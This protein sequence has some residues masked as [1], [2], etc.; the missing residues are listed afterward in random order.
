MGTWG[1]HFSWLSPVMC[2]FY[3]PPKIKIRKG[4]KD[5]HRYFIRDRK[6]MPPIVQAIPM[7]KA[8]ITFRVFIITKNWHLITF[9]YDSLD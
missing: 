3:S 6:D 4:R 7:K 1:T 8:H 2:S 9:I 5:P